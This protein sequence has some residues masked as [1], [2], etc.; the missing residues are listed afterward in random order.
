MLSK[1]EVVSLHGIPI[2][3]VKVTIS[4]GGMII[5]GGFEATASQVNLALATDQM[6]FVEEPTG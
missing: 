3:T 4:D 1:R 2:G 6:T 5:V